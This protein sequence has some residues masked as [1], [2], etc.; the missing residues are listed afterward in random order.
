MEEELKGENTEV[1]FL[2]IFKV[3]A[4]SWKKSWLGVFLVEFYCR[5]KFKI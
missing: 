3:S 5:R 2:P 4:F 1:G